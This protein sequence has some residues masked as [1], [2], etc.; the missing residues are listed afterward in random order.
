MT[1]DCIVIG[2]GPSGGSTA[3]HLAA[4]GAKVLLL[5]AKRLP[6]DKICSGI[7]TGFAE[8]EAK[9]I[10][11]RAGVAA[12]T[13]GSCLGTRVEG[14]GRPLQLRHKPLRFVDRRRLDHLVAD[15][16]A[17]RG[18]VILDETRLASA[19]RD[20]GGIWRVGCR[21]GTAAGEF[22]ARWLVDGTGAESVLA[23][24]LQPKA[25]YALA[26]DMHVPYEGD[27][28]AIIDWSGSRGGY[29]WLLPKAGGIASIGGGT[30]APQDWS[31]LLGRL[32]RYFTA[33][34]LTLAERLTGHR[35][36][37]ASRGDVGR[38][39][40]LLVGEAAGAMDRMFGEG[41]RSAFVTGRLAA[42]A[43]LDGG[44]AARSYNRTY[45]RHWRPFLRKR[46]FIAR[47]NAAVPLSPALHVPLLGRAMVRGFL[48]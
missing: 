1:W 12:A 31:A 24:R 43:I 36:R 48:G 22:R 23:R 20:D 4:A 10:I 34:G 44:D 42:Q 21:S 16:A 6:R 39:G 29:F 26:F 41:M 46:E 28:S 47:L 7:L 30:A 37:Y 11:G 45:C 32:R 40:L 18:A 3:Y 14:C 13:A 25:Q 38:D 33:R 8:R 5:E 9:A 2:A 17:A 15:A 27:A 19:R 35:L